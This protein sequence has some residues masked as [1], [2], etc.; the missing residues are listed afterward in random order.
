MSG[1]G[2]EHDELGRVAAGIDEV[3]EV[4][5]RNQ[6]RISFVRGRSCRNQEI[7]A[8]VVAAPKAEHGDGRRTR[9]AQDAL[10]LDWRPC[11]IPG[12]WGWFSL[13]RCHQLGV[14]V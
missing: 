14:P 10:R 7:P 2:I 5:R 11:L 1:L 3:G 4:N 8:F 9:Q 13:R 12:G 6:T